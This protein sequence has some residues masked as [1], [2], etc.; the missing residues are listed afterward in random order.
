MSEPTLY[1]ESVGAIHLHSDFSDGSLPIP[2]IAK[3]AADKELDFL[4]FSDHNTLEPKRQGLEGWYGPVLVL[5]GYEINDP[6]DRNHYLAFGLDQEV[7]DGLEAAEY[8]RRV[9]DQGGFGV[10]AHPAEKRNF[11]E[12][13]PP[14]PW[15]DWDVEGFDAI[16][17]WNQ[18]SEWMEGVTRSNIGWRILHPLR[19]IRFPVWETL[20]RWDR[21][22]R[23]RRVVGVGGIDVHAFQIKVFGLFPVEIYPYKVQFRSIHTHVLTSKPLLSNSGEKAVFSESESLIYEALR[24]GRCFITNSSLGDGLGFRF[25]ATDGQ[26]HF[27]MGSRINK[28]KDIQFEIETPLPGTIRLLCDG[29]VVVQDKGQELQFHSDKSGVYRVEVFRKRRGWIYSNPIVIQ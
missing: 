27:E 14:Y 16:E 10:I 24:M 6:D 5:I 9:R 8:V 29:Q 13:Y 26:K 15:T 12:A 7:G 1:F 19:S 23:F 21:L 17:I 3:I 4:M 2:E 28:A 20:E 22:N 11:S 25:Q 18:L